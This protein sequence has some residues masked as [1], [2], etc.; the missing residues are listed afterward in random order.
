MR[1]VGSRSLQIH[2]HAVGGSLPTGI[3]RLRGST[4]SAFIRWLF[5]DAA[6]PGQDD[7]LSRWYERGRR[8]V[9]DATTVEVGEG[10]KSK[11]A[12]VS[13]GSARLQ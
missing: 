9:G 3:A 6:R 12:N 13:V 7:V 4:T 2:Q 10:A 8:Q 1:A 5:A 11:L